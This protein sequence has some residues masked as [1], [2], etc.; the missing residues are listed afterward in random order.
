MCIYIYIYVCIE[1]ERCIC[2]SLSLSLSIYTH[3]CM[4]VCMHIYIYIYTYLYIS[5]S[6][7][8]YIYVYTAYI[9]PG[10]QSRS[11]RTWGVG[12]MCSPLFAARRM[13]I[14]HPTINQARLANLLLCFEFDFLTVALTFKADALSS[15]NL[16]TS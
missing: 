5:I 9:C 16:V 3:I 11:F 13:R 12:K 2:M 1:R 10:P 8:L 15:N 6:L 7:S 14:Q 4:Y